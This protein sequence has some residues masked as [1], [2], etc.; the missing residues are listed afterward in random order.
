MTIKKWFIVLPLV[1][2]SINAGAM[3]SEVAGDTTCKIVSL[4]DKKL[5]KQTSCH[6]NGAKGASM[7][8]AV[9][10]LNFDTT[11]GSRVTTINNASFR[12]GEAGEML[13][14]Q[15]TITINDEPA[16]VI[17]LDARTFKTLSETEID[18]LHKQKKPNFSKILECFRPIKD[19]KAFC[20]PYSL[21]YDM[22]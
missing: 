14:L 2:G 10:E 12:F 13:D 3:V 1:L 20:V 7:V 22:S 17:K 19:S 16:E 18:K 5:I 9:Q 8:Y 15:E 21:I 4:T 6:F 11:N